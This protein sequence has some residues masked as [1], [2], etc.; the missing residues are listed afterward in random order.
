MCLVT[1]KTAAA[2]EGATRQEV[3]AGVH[4]PVLTKPPALI[5]FVEATYPVE[6]QKQGLTA[7][8]RMLLTI[9]AD[10]LV[11]DVQVREPVGN[12]FDEA[13]VEAVKRF[14]FAPAEVDNAPAAVQIEYVY[15]FTL[16]P[17]DAGAPSADGVDA[18]VRVETAHL[19]G[20]LIARGSRTRIAGAVVLC[21]NHPDRET[22]SNQ[23]GQFDLEIEAG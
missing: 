1:A 21:A 14:T 10:G 23:D 16:A 17:P 5:Q 20:E 19:K 13:A 8:V 2:Y 4:V 7:S 12:G 22:S 6:A 3:D 11:P 9:G 18:G 15:H